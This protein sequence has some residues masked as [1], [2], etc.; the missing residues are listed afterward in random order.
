MLLIDIV[1]SRDAGTGVHCWGTSP[2]TFERGAM[3]AQDRCPYI[4]VS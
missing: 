4:P 3:G 2:L 1:G